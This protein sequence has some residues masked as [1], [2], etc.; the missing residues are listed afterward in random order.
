MYARCS[1]EDEMPKMMNDL[2]QA[3]TL[4]F[5]PS[6]SGYTVVEFYQERCVNCR[7]FMPVAEEFN[8]MLAVDPAEFKNATF[9][10]FNCRVTRR[11]RDLGIQNLPTIRLYY[12]PTKLSEFEGTERTLE[13]LISWVQQTI[14]DHMNGML[15][16]DKPS[17]PAKKSRK[18]NSKRKIK[19]VQA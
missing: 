10:Q 5:L 6:L 15:V 9:L 12:G 8:R 4:N 11:C 2:P 3:D 7:N 1:E 18:S 13:L 16:G 19:S 17:S 14:T